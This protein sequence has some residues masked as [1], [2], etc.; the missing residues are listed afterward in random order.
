VFFCLF[1]SGQV[2]MPRIEGWFDLADA[3]AVA[4]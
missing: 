3:P 2:K 1:A 4:A